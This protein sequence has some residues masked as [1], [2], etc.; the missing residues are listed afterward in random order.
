MKTQL[1]PVRCQE[2]VSGVGGWHRFQCSRKWTVEEADGT[3]HCKQHSAAKQAEKRARWDAE[4]ARRQKG[5]DLDKAMQTAT[6]N[7]IAWALR[8]YPNAPEV[9]QY[10][11][12]ADALTAHRKAGD[13]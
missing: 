10:V 11:K 4:S 12:A 6:D 1:D 13:Q 7:L 3:R 8:S 5:W 2:M 9:R